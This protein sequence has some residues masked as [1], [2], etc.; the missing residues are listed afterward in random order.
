VIA[1]DV[2]SEASGICHGFFTR[3][4][5]VSEGAYASLNCG[6][7]SGD[8]PDRVRINRA[9]TMA[10]FGVAGDALATACQVHSD[11]V[12]VVDAP[13]AVDER[14]RV[15]GLV[16]RTRGVALGILT[17][18]CTPVLFADAAAGVIGAAHAG[19]RGAR[20]GILEAT[21]AAMVD[22]G[23]RKQSMVAGIGPCIRQESYEIGPEFHAQFTA[24]DPEAHRL[25]R[26]SSREGHFL[27]DL[28]GYVVWRLSG[29]SIKAFEELPFDT[30]AD[31]ERFF[32]YRRTTLDGGGDYGRGLSAII[33]EP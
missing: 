1:A 9:R 33:L 13:W 11:R 5:G 10:R 15:D 27:F 12:A 19:W 6:L 24:D 7:G 21:V 18:D 23:A 20:A 28:P 14:P 31:A 32:S 29:L 16:T 2:L 8:D 17:A 30:C 26:P 22:L 3:R 25:F 4:G